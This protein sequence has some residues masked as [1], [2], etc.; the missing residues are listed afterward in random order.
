M[1]KRVVP[2]AICVFGLL[3]AASVTSAHAQAAGPAHPTPR[4]PSFASIF[5]SLP[6]DLKHLPSRDNLIVLGIGSGVALALH[7]LDDRTNQGLLVTEFFAPGKY[8]GQAYTLFGSGFTIY[9]VGRLKDQPKVSRV[10]A[11][12]VRALILDEAL[13]QAI[14]LSVRRERPDKS[15][16][17]SFPSGHSSA[18]FAF[19]TVLQQHLGWRAGGPLY[20]IASYV[21]T[22]RLHENRHFLSDVVFGAAVGVISGRTVTRRGR[23]P[24]P[25]TVVPLRGGVMVMY[26]R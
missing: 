7:P 17:H 19:A 12:L 15:N 5:T 10:G 3:L 6:G 4:H 8:L 21:A 22:S 9:A 18:T 26:A 16:R 14:K 24:L 20:F 25:V 13:T 23:D 2:G 11:D 1:S